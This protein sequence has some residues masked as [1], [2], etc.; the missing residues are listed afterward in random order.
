MSELHNVKVTRDDTRWE[1]EVTA[2]LPAEALSKYRD[3]AL[4]EIQKTA[5]LDGFRSGHAPIERII[6]VYGEG[7]IMRRAAEMA[8]QSELPELLAKEK[9]G[10]VEAPRVTTGEPENGKPLVFTARAAL[11]PAIELPD[12]RAVAAKLAAVK[13]DTSV[14]DAEHAEATLHLRRERARID[15]VEAGAEPAKAAEEARSMEEGQLPALDDTFAQSLGYE[16][17]AAFSEALRK[18]IQS[19]KELRAKERIRSSILDELVKSSKISYPASLLSYEL[20]DME[21]RF[22]DDLVQMGTTLEAFLAERQ[23]QEPSSAIKTPEALRESWK[24]AAD[25]RAKVRLILAD[26]ARKEGIEPDAEALAH[27]LEHAK[28]HYPQADPDMLR[29]H[30]AHAMRNE[31]TL[32]FLEGNTEKVGHTTED[33]SS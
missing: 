18:N 24:D 19:E 20:D 31:A 23:G 11:A 27:E 16:S 25:K 21:A 10:I 8:V 6:A 29:S 33:H 30:I 32:R 7:P 13:E 1:A 22:K 28:K 12:Y 3:V 17:A 26:I 5:V 9:V 2:E 14:S 15:K 4:R